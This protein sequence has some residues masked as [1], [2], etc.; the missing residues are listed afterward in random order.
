MTG[1]S[2]E[3]NR[4]PGIDIG[5]PGGYGTNGQQPRYSL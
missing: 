5:M 4:S 2:S 1:D 3:P